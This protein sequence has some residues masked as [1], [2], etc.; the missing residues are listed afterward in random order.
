MGHHFCHCITCKDEYFWPCNGNK[1]RMGML[2]IWTQDINQNLWY[3][4][5][6][7]ADS[8]LEDFER[9]LSEVKAWN[10]HKYFLHFVAFFRVALLLFI[11]VDNEKVG[12]GNEKALE[13]DNR[14][15]FS[16][17]SLFSVQ[18]YYPKMQQNI[19]LHSGMITPNILV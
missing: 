2:W 5:N 9:E 6:E 18:K 12:V 7:V 17:F 14:I 8:K 19:L 3:A 13:L 15:I 10:V 16:N 11:E 4:R 1:W